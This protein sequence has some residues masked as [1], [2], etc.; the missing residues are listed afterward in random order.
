M[1]LIIPNA[2]WL[3]LILTGVDTGVEFLRRPIS[4]M[5][6]T[7]IAFPVEIPNTD[8]NSD[9]GI[10]A[11][12]WR[13]LPANPKSCLDASVVIPT[14]TES[15]SE[16]VSADPPACIILAAAESFTCQGIENSSYFNRI[17]R[18]PADLFQ[19]LARWLVGK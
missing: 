13:L 12:E 5:A 15:S 4:N 18:C 10:L 17:Y 11:R 2:S 19:Q 8:D 1:P 6:N 14:A 3:H 7:W 16:L 9:N